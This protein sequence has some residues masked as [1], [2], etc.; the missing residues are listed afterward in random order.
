MEAD[1][2]HKTLIK[3][4]VD[5]LKQVLPN[6]TSYQKVSV[7]PDKTGL[8][9]FTRK[10]KYPGF[11]EPQFFGVKLRLVVGQ[12]SVGCLGLSVDMERA[13]GGQ[14]GEGLKSVVGLYAGVRGGLGSETQ[15]GPLAL[16][17]H[18]PA[19]HLLCILSMVAG[20]QT[21][22]AKRPSKVQ[23][24]ACFVRLLLVLFRTT[25]TGAVSYDSYWCCGGAPIGW[26]Y[27]Q[28][29]IRTQLHIDLTSEV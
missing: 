10:R 16:R 1:V 28:A 8:V 19:Y 18:R 11:F 23:R 14:G 12:V 13:G 24:L 26:P 22:S 5:F 29:P 15:G 2:R 3:A 27:F 25:A 17:L 21:A 6:T 4:I 7:N 9:A 20:C